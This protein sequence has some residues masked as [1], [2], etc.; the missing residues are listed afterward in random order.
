M[1]DTTRDEAEGQAPVTQLLEAAFR[2]G[3]AIEANQLISDVREQVRAEQGQAVN[4]EVQLTGRTWQYIRETVAPR[5]ALF[6]R[7]KRMS[8]QRCEPVFISIFVEDTL[9]FVS[10]PD[11]FEVVR[12]SEGLDEETFAKIARS[13]ERTGRR[14]AGALPPASHGGN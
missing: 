6:L 10:A 7:G 4:Y 9:H 2:V 13:W 14:S 12:R 8:V 5:L 11:L 3:P 1:S